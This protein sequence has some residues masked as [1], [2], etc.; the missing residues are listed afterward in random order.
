MSLRILFEDAALIVCE[1]P[2]GADAEREMPA[3]LREACG[4]ETFAV[5][6]LDRGVGGLMVFAK[7]AEAAAALSEQVRD[8]R[9]RKE[10]LAVVSGVPAPANG[11]MTDLLYHDAR[12]NK[13]Y[14]VK[15]P[16]KGVREAVLDY[17]T[18]A[19]SEAGG[20]RSL[21]RIRLQTGR[22]HQIRVQFASRKMPLCGDRRYGARDGGAEIALWS[23]RLAFFH[24]VS[25]EAIEF[26]LPAPETPP[27]SLF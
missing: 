16:R 20:V 3:L 21:V 24:P 10:Y 27:W 15:R 19:S 17:E 8:R 23:H 22:T 6:R 25:G 2:V 7:T 9:M 4:C 18:L 26:A 13:S 11:T 12:K 14:V 5:H 1:K